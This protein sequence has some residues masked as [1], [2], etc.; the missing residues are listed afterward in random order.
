MRHEVTKMMKIP[1]TRELLLTRY[2][3]RIYYYYYFYYY[4]RNTYCTYKYVCT[5][6]KYVHNRAAISATIKLEITIMKHSISK[7]EETARKMKGLTNTALELF[8]KHT[9]FYASSSI[10]I[11]ISYS[12]FHPPFSLNLVH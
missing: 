2:E 4:H 3:E 12:L 9:T 8:Q 7:G 10:P 5:I 6:V 1:R 11:A